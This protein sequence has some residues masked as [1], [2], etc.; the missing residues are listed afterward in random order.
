[1]DDNRA[2]VVEKILGSKISSD[3]KSMTIGL[4]ANMSEIKLDFSPTVLT[5]LALTALKAKSIL[6][7]KTSQGNP[8][9]S[10]ALHA[11]PCDGWE[12]RKSLDGA[13]L[14]LSFRVTGGAWVRVQVPSA[15]ATPIRETL[16]SA[17]GRVEMHVRTCRPN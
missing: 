9:D 6:D 10:G 14:L 4:I 17:E 12:I 1:M 5:T 13:F 8:I 2:V 7:A 11:F 3:G 15:A 16:E